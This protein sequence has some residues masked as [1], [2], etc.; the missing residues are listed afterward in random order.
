M[1]TPM[2]TPP[3]AD[4]PPQEL[5]P[6]VSK[7][8]ALH[9]RLGE[10]ETAQKKPIQIRALAALVLYE[11]YEY[12]IA[13]ICREMGT[14]R[15]TWD[16][17]IY[18]H[19]PVD[20][21]MLPDWDK[22]EALERLRGAVA[23]RERL[24][25]EEVRAAEERDEAI[26]TLAR[27]ASTWQV[28]TWTGISQ[29]QIHTI[30]NTEPLDGRWV[31]LWEAAGLLGVTVGRIWDARNSDRK[32]G[33]PLPEILRYRGRIPMMDREQLIHWWEGHLHH[34]LQSMHE[35]AEHIGRATGQ[36]P[37]YDQVAN[38]LRAMRRTGRDSRVRMVRDGRAILF[39]PES[40]LR[41]WLEDHPK[42]RAR[43]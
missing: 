32:R 6:I 16:R 34:W 37:T 1:T 24:L 38:W 25:A 36:Q 12:P 10:L 29:R 13:E 4:A 19:A 33:R 28:S 18:P 23:E 7:A 9:Q 11:Y 26:R 31:T 8:A 21:A 3:P 2:S 20:P 14:S 42:A 39:E 27:S 40:T 5:R 30:A 22:D 17:N 41:A 15:N 43:R 35:V